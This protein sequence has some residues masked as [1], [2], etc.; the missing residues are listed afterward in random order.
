MSNYGLR[1]TDAGKRARLQDYFSVSRSPA[2]ATASPEAG[3]PAPPKAEA[4]SPPEP[5]KADP[6][7]APTPP[8][9]S[10][11]QPTPP[12][13]PKPEAKDKSSKEK[14]FDDH[15]VLIC[16]LQDPKTAWKLIGNLDTAAPVIQVRL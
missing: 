6:L 16:E 12:V 15:G 3:T 14:N 10:Q 4:P 1:W 11:P 5:P 13:P 2:P 9:P 7:P 8:L